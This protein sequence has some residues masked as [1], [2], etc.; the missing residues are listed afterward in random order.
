MQGLP[1]SLVRPAPSPA[2]GE[3]ERE[4]A[5]LPRQES[6]ARP[7]IPPF[8]P[9]PGLW[10]S[11]SDASG[12]RPRS[13]QGEGGLATNL[14]VRD[15]ATDHGRDREVRSAMRELPHETD[16][17]PVR[18]AEGAGGSP[19][20]RVCSKCGLKR[21]LEEF[22]RRS[23]RPLG[24]GAVCLACGR[25]YRRAH[26]ARNVAYYVEKAARARARQRA[27]N[28]ERLIAYLRSHPCVDCG[29]TDMRVLQFDHL[30]PS[31]KTKEVSRLVLWATWRRAAREIEKCAV[32]CGNCHRRRTLR[33]RRSGANSISISEDRGA[34]SAQIC[35]I[36]V[37]RAVSSV[38]RAALF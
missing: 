3:C 17:R 18:L 13:R 27:Q 35:P 25:T 9:L 33:Q 12:V 31:A 8:T 21:P 5:P 38:D 20:T 34:W 1:E 22:P 4:H 30:D 6:T 23:D 24:R 7:R 26:Y 14:V 29:E 19:L 37:I 36:I 28:Y 15:A 10:R 2:R 16:G 32:R 11:G